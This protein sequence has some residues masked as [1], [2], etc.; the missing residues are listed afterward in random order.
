MS[1]DQSPNSASGSEV[2]TAARPSSQQLPGSALPL[3]EATL[4]TA[5]NKLADRMKSDM[6]EQFALLR[7]EMERLHSRVYELEQHVSERDDAINELDGRI[8]D[9]D[10]R[11]SKL[12]N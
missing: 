1:R 11:I 3:T 10:R 6:S 7:N 4:T 9:R 2:S 12:E 5:L 8:Y